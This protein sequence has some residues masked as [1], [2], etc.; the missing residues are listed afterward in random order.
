[1]IHAR[2]LSILTF[3]PRARRVVALT[4]ISAMVVT[5]CAVQPNGS[6]GATQT[7]AECITSYIVVGAIVGAAAG[8]LVSEKDSRGRGAVKGAVVGG[9]T[10]YAAAWMGCINK[11]SRPTT[12]HAMSRESV[13]EAANYSAQQGTLLR[14]RSAYIDPNAST[15]GGN[16][17]MRVAYSVLDGAKDVKVQQTTQFQII[18]ANG[19]QRSSQPSR[20]VVTVE[21][22]LNV[23]TL[24]LV[25]PQELVDARL[26]AT[27]TLEV[28]GRSVE[29]VKEL[30]ITRDS[31]KLQLA[32]AETQR[33]R[34]EYEQLLTARAKPPSTT[35]AA[36]GV[37][38][39]QSV[40]LASGSKQIA[41]GV[42]SLTVTI[43]RANL[44]DQP[45][46]KGNVLGTLLKGAVV[47]VEAEVSGAEG[48]WY[49]VEY[50]GKPVWVGASAGKVE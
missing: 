8:A 35:A 16:V 32:Q 17:T 13:P 50:N 41:A 47:P 10:G 3:V 44:R 27:L 49:R 31:G 14:V 11:F 18:L 9:V 23:V 20:D 42:K 22:G 4:V 39:Y 24:P 43:A 12:V 5:G 46:V 29:T 19:E 37:P 7:Q 33:N 21:P 26:V 25:V 30:Y 2:Q 45:S 40:A 48:R 34:A 1:M 28:N 15:P 38:E 36:S 6:S